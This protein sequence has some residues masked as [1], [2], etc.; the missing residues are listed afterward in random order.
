M[1]LSSETR[2]NLKKLINTAYYKLVEPELVKPRQIRNGVS[3]TSSSLT[4]NIIRDQQPHYLHQRIKETLYTC[5][6]TPL[7]GH[8]FNN[9]QE[10]IGKHLIGFYQNGPA[11]LKIGIMTA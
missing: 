9:S 1:W 11:R 8:F 2:W 3:T 10:K 5:R 6:L 7:I 4:M